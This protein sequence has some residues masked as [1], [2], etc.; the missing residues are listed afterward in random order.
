MDIIDVF[1]ARGVD[2]DVGPYVEIASCGH[3]QA[4]PG[5]WRVGF[6]RSLTCDQ[7]VDPLLIQWASYEGIA[8]VKD[9]WTRGKL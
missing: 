4:G 3:I 8:H 6:W 7:C 1:L 9:R 5:P 2:M